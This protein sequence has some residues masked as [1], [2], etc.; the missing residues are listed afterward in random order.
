LWVGILFIVGLIALVVW[1]L[2]GDAERRAKLKAEIAQREQARW[3]DLCRR[4]GQ[5]MAGRIWRHEVW[6]GQTVDQLIEARG[7]PEDYNDQGAARV[8]VG[9]SGREPATR[10]ASRWR[11][12][13]WSAERCS[14]TL[15]L[16]WGPPEGSATTRGP[17][18]HL[19]PVAVPA[20]LARC[21]TL[22]AAVA[23]T[24]WPRRRGLR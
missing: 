9:S 16:T 20:S 23:G 10:C 15:A 17:A 11:T 3:D 21:S 1:S 18:S 8:Q 5:D 4:W 7:R 13:S 2:H 6:Q 19:V 24:T 12:A 22:M 14:R